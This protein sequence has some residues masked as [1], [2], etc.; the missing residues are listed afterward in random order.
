MT[1]GK[2][3]HFAMGA[4]LD[5]A[6]LGWWTWS[7]YREK[8]EVVFRFISIYQPCVNKQGEMSVYAQ[9]KKYLQDH[10][11]DRDPRRAFIEDFTQEL[12]EWIEMGDNIVVGGDVNESVFH[13]T[14]A[15]VFQQ[16][17]MRNVVFDMHLLVWL[18]G[19]SE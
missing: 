16:F 19:I 9:H 3:R 13:H 1:H 7:Q 15:S 12:G 5:K 2:L 18:K 4:G 14:I 11:D 10:D 8:G 6:Q 17:H